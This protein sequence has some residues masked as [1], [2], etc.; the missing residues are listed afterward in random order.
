MTTR[1]DKRATILLAPAR[2]PPVAKISSRWLTNTGSTARPTSARAASSTRSM[3][4]SARMD[5]GW[6]RRSLKRL[7]S[8]GHTLAANGRRPQRLTLE[9]QRHPEL[10]ATSAS[11][12]R[13]SM[14]CAL[15][16]PMA[17]ETLATLGGL[18]SKNAAE[19]LPRETSQ[20]PGRRTARCQ[21]RAASWQWGLV[22]LHTSPP[23][24]ASRPRSHAS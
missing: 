2:T 13:S 20:P 21:A 22:P 6:T 11:L 4:G 17:A 9:V 10:A 5:L 16:L 23:A 1:I 18:P 14:T 8:A 15:A 24:A 7:E 19:G 12:G 3:P